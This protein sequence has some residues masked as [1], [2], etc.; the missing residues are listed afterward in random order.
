MNCSKCKKKLGCLSNYSSSDN[1]LCFDCE[2]IERDKKE[3]EIKEDKV[4]TKIDEEL[5]N[6]KQKSKKE[7]SMVTADDSSIIK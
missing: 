7:Y 1:P 3:Q 6:A 5:C 4:R 2:S